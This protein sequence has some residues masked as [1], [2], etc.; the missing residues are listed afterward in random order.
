MGERTCADCGVSSADERFVKDKRSPTGWG[1]Y[2]LRCNRVRIR[3]VQRRHKDRYNA[4]SREHYAANKEAILAQQQ[5]YREANIERIREY[6]R[7]RYA[8][9]PA[10]RREHTRRWIEIPENAERVR[11][12]RRQAYYDNR[13][14]HL[15][16]QT[17]ARINAAGFNADF[18][19][20][21]RRDV[22]ESYGGDCGICG[23]P[24]PF[25]DMELD[26]I[27]PISKGGPHLYSNVQPAHKPCN[28][29]KKDKE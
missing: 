9:N 18:E 5:E 2:C 17:Q 3:A 22:W 25:E 28:S 26:H 10:G 29:R 11:Q 24:V 4:R 6:D 1:S 8:A 13:D 16:R 27:K 21:S 7:E 23:D 15:D 20:I 12:Q 19:P 14:L